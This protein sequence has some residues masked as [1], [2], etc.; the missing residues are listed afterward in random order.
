MW[1]LQSLQFHR[2]VSLE[3]KIDELEGVIPYA[4]NVR[5][6]S[7]SRDGQTLIVYNYGPRDP[8]TY[9]LIKDGQLKTV[10]SKQPLL[11]SEELADVK[12][13]SWEAR[14]GK[15]IHGYLTVPHGEPPFPLIVLP[16][17]GPFVS[18]TVSWDEWGQML[19]N[20]GYLVLQ[21][22]FR[23]SRNYGLDYYMSA[24]KDGGQGGYKMQDD[25]DDGALYLVEQG[26]ADKDRIALFGYAHVPWMA[27]NQRMIPEA[28]LPGAAE[29]ARQARR[30]D[31]VVVATDAQ[32][33]AQKLLDRFD[34]GEFDVIGIRHQAEG[35]KRATT[36]W[37]AAELGYLPVVIEQHRKGKLRVRATLTD[38]TP[39]EGN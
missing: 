28:A 29:R 33:V 13:V 12:Y 24:F 2:N 17:G 10:G 19:A 38:Y 36:L 32:E 15:T 8:G 26:L 30:L 5:I 31:E 1:C 22:Q 9:Y 11:K 6:N 35:S 25:K 4:Y 37:C 21:P 14:D 7:R 20:N 34:A 16:H 39:T 23:G 18:E 27:K 3:C